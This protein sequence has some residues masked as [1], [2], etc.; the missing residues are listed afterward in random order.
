MYAEG[1]GIP[2]I[3]FVWPPFKVIWSYGLI[4]FYVSIRYYALKYAYL[5]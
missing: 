5:H 4:A 1:M 3:S 2:L